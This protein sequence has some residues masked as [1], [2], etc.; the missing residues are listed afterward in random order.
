MDLSIRRFGAPARGVV[1]VHQAAA[2]ARR[3]RVLLCRP[4]GQ[5]ATRTAT[6]F[7]VVSDRLSREG[8]DVLRFDHHGTGDSPGE[9]ADQ[10]LDGWVD[11]TL[12]AHAELAPEPGMPA[13]WFGMGLGATLALKAALRTRHPPQHLLLWEPVLDGRAY[14]QALLASHRAELAREFGLPWGRLLRL[15]KVSEPAVPGDVLGFHMGGR[16]AQDL[17]GLKL[18][19]APALRRGMRVTCAIHADQ[20]PLLAD[21]PND[22]PHFM[23]HIVEHRIDWHSSQAQGTAIVPPDLLNLLL[24]A[25]PRR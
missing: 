7:R 13:F 5:E 20:R 10:H 9:E 16:L 15:G 22:D 24:A 21:C 18:S 11:D 12:A 17:N 3:A 1:G 25:L 6:I 23:Q 4:L 19:A 14:V 8:C 2:G